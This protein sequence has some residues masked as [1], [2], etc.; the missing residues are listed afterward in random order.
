[1]GASCLREL[2]HRQ[3]R[4]ANTT[5]RLRT[6]RA[7]TQNAFNRFRPTLRSSELPN[8]AYYRL[9]HD[10]SRTRFAVRVRPA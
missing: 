5:H 4:A 1:V 7:T 8:Q 10:N 3:A 9:N 2:D 6:Q